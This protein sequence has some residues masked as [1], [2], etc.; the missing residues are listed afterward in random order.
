MTTKLSKLSFIIVSLVFIL[1]C[2]PASNETKTEQSNVSANTEFDLVILNGRVI[3]PETNFDAVQ[4]VGIKD[5]EIA[6]ITADDING[7]ETIDA[8]NQ[9]VSPGFIDIHAHG[10]N[11]GDYRMQAMQGV[12]TM[13][14]LESGVLPVGPWYEGQAAK[15]LPLNYGTASGWTYARIATF[16]DTE[17]EAT[18]AYFQNAQK[19]LD[20]KMNIASPDQ[21]EKILGYVEE[22]LNDGALG[23]GINAG[24]APGYGQKEYYALAKMAVK[25]DVAT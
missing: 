17:P 20:W 25:H 14:E 22:G 2:Q 4:N 21:E 13:L 16:S 7:K 24:Y 8:T 12:T 1:S 19:D 23:I 6:I 9:V 11:I 5:G 3:D 15:K 10:Q 18:V